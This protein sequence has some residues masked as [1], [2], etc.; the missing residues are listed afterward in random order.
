[1]LGP[2]DVGSRVVVRRVVGT[3]DGR[4]LFSDALG[5]LTELT[6]SHLT[7][8]TARGPLH[9]SLKDVTRAK[10]VPPSAAEMITLELAADDAWPAADQ[11]R[12][13]NWRL[14]ATGGWTGRANS[15]LPIG[16]PGRPLDEAID[17]VQDWYAARV[18]PPKINVPMPLAA[19]V[20]AALDARGWRTN[21]VVL[22]QTGPLPT[23]V[24]SGLPPVHL[25]E[26]PS[27]A[28]LSVIAGR[29]GKPPAAAVRLLTAVPEVRFASVYGESGELLAVARGTVT[30][31]H[32]F[33]IALVEVVPEA[34][35]RGLAQ[36]VVGGL[37][38]WAAERG[39][40][41]AFLQVEAHN[42]PALA[43]YA[44]LGFTTHHTY[45]TRTAAP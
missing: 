4:P 10:R 1:V 15:A 14:R 40:R 18:L 30:G 42:E 8:Q 21:P 44:R 29:K 3:R 24:I 41:K 17:A 33:G 12:L 28:W 26:T 39:A 37:A 38:R 16:S 20:N 23:A 11:A 19:R 32:Y 25:S 43:L 35:R 31:G 27:D 2:S 34:R 6:G 7:V 9:V 36:H 13:G 22:V 45:L 5:E